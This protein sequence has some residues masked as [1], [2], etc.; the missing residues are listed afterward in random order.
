MPLA[1][2][3]LEEP[4]TFKNN[5]YTLKLQDKGG[6]LKGQEGGR[7]YLLV[8]ND[9]EIDVA[10]WT[11][12]NGYFSGIN[13]NPA[14]NLKVDSSLFDVQDIGSD[15]DSYIE[16][17]MRPNSIL[18]LDVQ[19]DTGAWS[20][21]GDR[22]NQVITQAGVSPP[23][24]G[25]YEGESFIAVLTNPY[26]QY[27]N[28]SILTLRGDV[29]D[30]NQIFKQ[31][32][33]LEI[34]AVRSVDPRMQEREG[35]EGVEEELVDTTI[36][37]S[38]WAITVNNTFPDGAIVTGEDTA[39]SNWQVSI[40]EQT[41]TSGSSSGTIEYAVFVD[42]QLQPET[43]SQYFASVKEHY[44]AYIEA[45]RSDTYDPTQPTTWDNPLDT[46]TDAAD[47]LQ[48]A[49]IFLIIAIGGLLVLSIINK[50]S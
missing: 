35:Y 28:A 12:R 36:S 33:W 24:D 4:Y 49:G 31:E 6:I 27:S 38:E 42:G 8:A 32:F 22:F 43:Q 10:I 40:R 9:Y 20:Y 47:W 16:F 45:R 26:G 21:S 18:G 46:V 17:T 15:V 39:N 2:F 11:N 41:T 50:R 37:T 25:V 13:D 23:T 1:N 3:Y 7:V 30:Y 44:L 48:G 14:Y 5:G 29:L 19:G 34:K